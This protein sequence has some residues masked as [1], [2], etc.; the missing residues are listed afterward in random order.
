MARLERIGVLF[1]AILTGIMM[2]SVLAFGALIGTPVIIG[3]FGLIAGADGAVLYNFAAKR[4]GG[5]EADFE[6]EG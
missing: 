5:V 6:L 3:L 2:T 4:F 1:S